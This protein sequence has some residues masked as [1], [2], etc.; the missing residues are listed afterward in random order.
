MKDPYTV[1]IAPMV[2]EKGTD[3]IAKWNKYPFRVRI[4]ANKNDIKHAIESVFSVKVKSVH[5]MKRRGKKKRVR[6]V[7]GLTSS[8][9]KAI[10]TLIEGD[11]IEMVS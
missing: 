4:S 11:K 2:T 3:Q 1:L 6:Q 8:W 7:E 10:V 5:T 9:K